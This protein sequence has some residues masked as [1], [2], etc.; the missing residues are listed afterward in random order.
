M[1]KAIKEGSED[2]T[3]TL[4]YGARSQKDLSQTINAASGIFSSQNGSGKPRRKIKNS[5]FLKQGFYP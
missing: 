2:F 3:L 1:M 5:R 4:I